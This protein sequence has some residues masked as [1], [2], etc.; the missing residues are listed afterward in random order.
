MKMTKAAV[1]LLFLVSLTFGGHH[2]TEAQQ[3]KTK[4]LNIEKLFNGKEGTINNSLACCSA[5][6][7]SILVTFHLLSTG[8]YCF[9]YKKV[10]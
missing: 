8:L 1:I 4:E 6:G 5:M 9:I 7:S 3:G 2:A 10:I